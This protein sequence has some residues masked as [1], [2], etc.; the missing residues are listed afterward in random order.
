MLQPFLIQLSFGVISVMPHRARLSEVLFIT[1]AYVTTFV[2]KIFDMTKSVFGTHPQ[3]DNEW[4]DEI[5]M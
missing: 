5:A 4:I 2:I 3:M 1:V